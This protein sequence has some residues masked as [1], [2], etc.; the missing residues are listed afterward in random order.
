VCLCVCV[1]VYMCTCVHVY[2]CTCVRVSV[3]ANYVIGHVAQCWALNTSAGLLS[4]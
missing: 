2:M 4:F 1:C 3:C